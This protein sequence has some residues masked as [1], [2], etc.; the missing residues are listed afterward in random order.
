MMKMVID[1]EFNTVTMYRAGVF[2]ANRITAN[3]WKSLFVFD[4]GP[5]RTRGQKFLLMSKNCHHNAK[6]SATGLFTKGQNLVA[7]GQTS[8]MP[9]TTSGA[10]QTETNLGQQKQGCFVSEMTWQVICS[11]HVLILQHHESRWR[12]KVTDTFLFKMQ[13][14]PQYPPGW[15]YPGLPCGNMFNDRGNLSSSPSATTSDSLPESLPFSEDSS[16]PVSTRENSFAP[17]IFVSREQEGSGQ[18]E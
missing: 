9:S 15:I 2:N 14:F 6:P 17:Y 8:K 10:G 7:D 13:Q 12:R 18:M 4:L 16:M 3:D 1:T 5:S 11:N